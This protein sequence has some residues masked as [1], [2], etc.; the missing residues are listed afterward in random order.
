MNEFERYLPERVRLH[1]EQEYY[2]RVNA[3]ATLEQVLLD[4][5]FV[6]NPLGHVAL[7]SDHGVVHVRDIARQIL[8][9]LDAINGVLIPTRPQNRLDFFMK[10]YG[11]MAAYLHDIGMVDFSPFGRSMH[12][13]F[14]SQ[15]VF[16]PAFDDVVETL[17]EENCGNI[18][19]RLVNLAGKDLL[20]QPPKI[21]FREMLSLVN[22]HSK[23]KVPIGALNDPVFLRQIMQKSL[24]TDLQ[25]LY[26]EQYD[27]KDTSSSA[28]GTQSV[29]INQRKNLRRWY[30]DFAGESFQW[31]VSDLPQ[32]IELREDV[33]DTLRALR[34]ADALRQRGTVLKTS[35]NYEIFVDAVTAHGIYA[36]RKGNEQLFLISVQHPL[37]A[38]EANLASSELG[39]DGNL[40][41]A[42]QRGAFFD[43]TAEAWA[44]YS[45][46]VVVNDIQLDVIESFQRQSAEGCQKSHQDILILLEGVDDNHE[47]TGS[48]VAHLRQLNPQ[49]IRQVRT[50][51]S[52]QNAS[53]SEIERYLTAG[54]VDQDEAYRQELIDQISRSGHNVDGM[55]LDAA[56]EHVK[57]I[58]LRAQE[59]LIEAGSQASFVYFPLDEGL[60]VIPLGGYQPFS[61]RAWMPL[62]STG[63]IRGATRNASVVADK[64]LTLLMIPKEV[65][66]R[67]WHKPYALEE[68]IQRVTSSDFEKTQP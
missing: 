22:C 30:T 7:F 54:E 36:L 44:A 60:K 64:D 35:G 17:W 40:R 5:E 4:P 55:N 52:L 57:L 6:Q 14:A 34:C 37:V 23:S 51:A 12:P 49:I 27:V 32:I 39:R 21:V 15:M 24:A 46:A 11:V 58:T 28:N 31:L 43:S 42:F 48:V 41:I 18:A 16:D 50:V 9:V 38:G 10:G 25:S 8:Q 53:S 68:F 13:E 26:H 59:T 63:V 62:G 56:F 2:A 20:L 65:Y 3:Q 33:I 19:W 66:L 29:S 47:F 67:H 1:I 45:A 61:V